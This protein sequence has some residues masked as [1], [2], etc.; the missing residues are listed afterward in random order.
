MSEPPSIHAWI[1]GT[2]AIG[3]WLDAFY[4]EVG[5]DPL[6]APVFGG[7]V[8]RAHRD[9]VTAWW[10]EVMGGPATYTEELGGYA[11]MLAQHRGLRITDEQRLRF[12]TLLSVAAD[13]AGLPADPEA[14]S[15]L[16][17]YAEWGSRLAVENSADDARP[18]E[19]ARSRG[20]AGAWRRRTRAEG[21]RQRSRSDLLDRQ[22]GRG[23]TCSTGEEGA[24]RPARP[25]RKAR[26][27][28]LD[29]QGGRG[30]TCS[31]GEAGAQVLSLYS[32]SRLRPMIIFWMSAVP[33]P[34]SMK[35]ASR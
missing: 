35:A 33:S 18:V 27:D 10:A 23:A 25:A 17:A 1:G 19:R 32:L 20:G 14:R 4:D 28:L 3:R 8:T 15:A 24:E 16:M 5:R 21:S 12:V 29:R 31:T 7:V 34:I 26:S 6:L 9:H 22:G 11:H 2:E 13:T 30:A